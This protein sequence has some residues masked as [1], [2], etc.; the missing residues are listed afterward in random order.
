M[1]VFNLSQCTKT[2]LFSHL[3]SYITIYQHGFMEQASTVAK[4][5]CMTQCIANYLDESIQVDEVFIDLFEAFDR[6]DHDNLLIE[7]GNF[8]LSDTLLSFFN[9]FLERRTKFIECHGF[10]SDLIEETSGV[11]LLCSS[12]SSTLSFRT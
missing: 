7:L 11:P 8:G 9:S 3:Q 2:Y 1:T 5:F 10:K 6:L 4:I 12:I